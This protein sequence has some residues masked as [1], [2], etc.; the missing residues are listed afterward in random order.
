MAE[1]LG[2]GIQAPIIG[3]AGADALNLGGLGF[4]KNIPATVRAGADLY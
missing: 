2:T 1:D 4:G 3:Q